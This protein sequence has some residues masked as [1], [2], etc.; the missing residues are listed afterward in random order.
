MPDF[1][2]DVQARQQNLC[3]DLK[4]VAR[5]TIVMLQ[6]KFLTSQVLAHTQT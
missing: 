3:A 5:G 6:K 2:H 4:N 1:R